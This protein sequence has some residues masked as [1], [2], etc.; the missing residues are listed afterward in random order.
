[1]A[2]FKVLPIDESIIAGYVNNSPVASGI[3]AAAA[4]KQKSAEKVGIRT[5]FQCIAQLKI[6][7]LGI[8]MPV[9]QLSGIDLY[10]LADIVRDLKPAEHV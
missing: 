1:M 7:G 10:S 3:A 9:E 4:G 8:Q 6:E 2:V 5:I